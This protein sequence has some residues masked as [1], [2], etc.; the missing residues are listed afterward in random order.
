MPWSFLE[1][2]GLNKRLSKQKMQV[3]KYLFEG[4]DWEETEQEIL[5]F[6]KSDNMMTWSCDY[7]LQVTLNKLQRAVNQSYWIKLQVL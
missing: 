4:V 2:M 7:N 6:D 5:V 3:L 1:L